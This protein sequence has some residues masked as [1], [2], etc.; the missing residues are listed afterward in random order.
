MKTIS[1]QLSHFFENK[2]LKR[3][4]P[5]LLRVIALVVVV[6]AVFT[7]LFHFIMFYAEGEYHSWITGLYWTL[8]VMSTLGFGD[9]T[10]TTDIG[11]LF[12]VV[13]LVTGIVLLLVV[14]PFAFI[15]FFYAPWLKAQI[16]NRAPD[17]VPADIENHVIITDRDAIAPGLIDALEREDIPYFLIGPDAATASDWYI[18]G[19]SAVVGDTDDEATYEKLRVEQA[20]L[21]F[22]NR[23]NAQNTNMT[24]T[25]REVAPDVP[26]AAVAH[27]NN[28]VD[29]LEMSGATHVLPLKRWLGEQLS[30][31]VRAQQVGLQSLG[32]YG[33]LK[34]AEVPVRNTPLS[35]QKIRETELRAKTGVNI[36]GIWERGPLESPD[37][38]RTLTDASVAVVMGTDSQLEQLYERVAPE[39]REKKPVVVIGGGTVG[40]AA[41]RALAEQDVPV[42]LVE[43]RAERCEM[44]RDLCD[45]VYEGDASNYTILEEAGILDASAVL[46]T[47]ND[48]AI[49]V[50]LAS[51]CRNLN[52]NLRIVSRITRA[53]NLDAI[54]RAG[55]DFVLSYATLGVDALMSILRGKE[56]MVLGEGVDLFARDL[57]ESLE[58]VTLSE[59]H[60]GAQ[61]GLTL[62]ALNDGE[63][64]LTELGPSV[65][66]ES[67]MELLLI[68][69][70]AQLEAFI[71]EYE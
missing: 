70:D 40:E 3:N 49:N 45:N 16:R 31:R 55:A 53:R 44:L 11:R 23:D 19:V 12:S 27:D 52:S 22:A 71:D 25:A 63:E 46:L 51:Y 41:V 5:L 50:Y 36:I 7:V 29:I 4:F 15:R 14:L 35:G 13:V 20:R 60:I 21:L 2:E 30:N 18:D 8:T 64:T 66:F 9:I 37:P 24:L 56:L 68:G 32:E 47:T 26:I 34:I 43:Q 6:I 39:E 17:V 33:N 67:G 57:P 42:N 61:T 38:S 62:V 10:F 69:S 54:Y 65:E 1:T 58:G 48:D 59:S 28:A